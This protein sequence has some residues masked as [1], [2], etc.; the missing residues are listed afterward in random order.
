M[1]QALRRSQALRRQQDMIDADAMVL[2]PGTGLI[3][4]EG[5][6]SG[7]AMAGAEG[8]GVAEIFDLR[9]AARDSGWNSASFIQALGS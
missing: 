9:S 1:P 8:V 4:P 6:L 2:A 5:V 7:C 3:V